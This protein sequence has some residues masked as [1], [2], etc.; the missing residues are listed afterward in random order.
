MATDITPTSGSASGTDV[1]ALRIAA[2]ADM[3]VAN[4]GTR[5]VK[6]LVENLDGSPTTLTFTRKG[7]F[8][9]GETMGTR[10][11]VVGA[12]DLYLLQD[13]PVS[14]FGT[15]LEFSVSNISNATV[16]ALY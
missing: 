6:L 14:E 9:N 3:K 8:A 2:T 1:S 5:P 4:E 11:V 16:L 10:A 7:T 15:S 13:F 12:A